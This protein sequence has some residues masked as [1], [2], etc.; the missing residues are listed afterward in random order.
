MISVQ[1]IDSGLKPYQQ[2]LAL[3][4]KLFD[5]NLAA[6]L[7]GGPTQN[8]LILCEHPPVFTLGKSGKRENI[9]VTDEQMEAEFYQVNRGGD[10]TFH[11]PGQLVVY[12]IFDLESLSIG[13][14]QYIYLLEETIIDSLK[15]FGL[16][17]ERIEGA[18]GI[19]LKAKGILPDRKICAIG[20][21]VSRMVTMH[22]LAIN[23]NTQLNYFNK[24][25][26]CGI[27]DKGVTSLQKES[28]REIPMEAYKTVFLE[29]FAKT[30]G[31]V[32]A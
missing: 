4:E 2:V 15:H 13:V 9:L 20:A 12:P 7:A 28:G 29:S 21:K 22:G 17:G 1:L 32:V 5:K 23:I 16:A 26:A 18:A 19:W 8:Y 24:I 14:N 3:Q 11:G 31:V 27:E 25:T 6:K 10:V 30:F